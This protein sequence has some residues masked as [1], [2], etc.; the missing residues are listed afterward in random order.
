MTKLLKRYRYIKAAIPPVFVLW[1]ILMLALT[2]LPSNTLPDVKIFSY[3]K[4]GHFGMFGGWTFF[5]GLYMIV[6]KQKAHINLILLMMTGILFGVLIEVLQYLL[7]SNRTASLG[8]VIANSL[9]CLTAAL[10]LHP[11]KIYLKRST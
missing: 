2:L 6:Y 11:I 9:G 8:D 3:D 5:L 4:I 1:T 10:L 7:P